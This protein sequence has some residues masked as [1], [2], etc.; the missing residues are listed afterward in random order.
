MGLEPT[1]VLTISEL[2]KNMRILSESQFQ[3]TSKHNQSDTCI[4][5][6]CI[7]SYTCTIIV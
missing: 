1:I 5:A 4:V 3:Y 2:V 7:Y 6:Y